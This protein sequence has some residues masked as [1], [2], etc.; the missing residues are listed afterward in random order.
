MAASTKRAGFGT[1]VI[2]AMAVAVTGI[3]PIAATPASAQTLLDVFFG[4][5]T[6][7]RHEPQRR[8]VRKRVYRERT[9]ARRAPSRSQSQSRPS[10][11][12]S[13]AYY[14]TLCV[15]KADGFFFPMSFSTTAEY[16]QQDLEACQARCPTTDV[17]L[18]VHRVLREEP[19][20]MMSFTTD[21]PYTDLATAFA[22]KTVG[23]SREAAEA[24]RAKPEQIVAER[25]DLGPLPFQSPIPRP[26][27][28]PDPEAVLVSD[29][30]GP[31]G[32]IADVTGRPKVIRRV[33]PRFFPDQ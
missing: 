10:R 12:K 1:S 29:L 9:T 13:V 14:R 21:E 23:L 8:V 11:P 27:W 18:Y 33:G 22:Y 5:S 20:D 16:F 32:D 31:G 17:D 28:R 7:Q 24:C 15:R 3:S 19:Q 30:R 4:R 2:L 26:S 25:P 6:I